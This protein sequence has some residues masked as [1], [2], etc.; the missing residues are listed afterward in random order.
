MKIRI[1]I[2]KKIFQILKYMLFFTF[3][4]VCLSP[5]ALVLLTTGS[6]DRGLDHFYFER[7]MQAMALFAGIGLILGGLIAVRRHEIILKS[8][9]FRD[10]KL[11]EVTGSDLEITGKEAFN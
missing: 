9:L 5:A 2:L 10:K 4:L 11:L 1:T 7:R 3:F 6:L 8:R